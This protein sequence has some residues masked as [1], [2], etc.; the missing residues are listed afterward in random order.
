L[1]NGPGSPASV[2][3]WAANKPTRRGAVERRVGLRLIPTFIPDAPAAAPAPADAD[4][5]GGRP[6]RKTR[7]PA[8]YL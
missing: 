1:R 7:P 3:G 2:R 8:R 5:E 6:R 4:A